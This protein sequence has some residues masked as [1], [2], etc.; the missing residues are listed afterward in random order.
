MIININGLLGV[1]K[2]EVAWKPIEKF[3]RA[4]MRRR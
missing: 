4:S 3:E 2:T 1:G